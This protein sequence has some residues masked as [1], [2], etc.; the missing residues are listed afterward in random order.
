MRIEVLVSTMHQKDY[1]LLKRMNIKTD[2]IV[3]NQCDTSSHKEFSFNNCKIIWINTKQRGL[4]KSRNM[5][6]SYATGDI[7]VIAD[8]DVKYYDNYASTIYNAYEKEIKADLICFNFKALNTIPLR[9]PNK[10]KESPFYKSY[11][12]VS[13]SFKRKKIEKFGL[14]FNELIG[15]GSKYGAGEESLFLIQSRRYGL[16]IFENSGYIAEV[17][18]SSS[19]WFKGYNEKFYFDKGVYLALAYGKMAYFY[20]FYFILQS[21]KISILPLK[22]VIDNILNGIR[23]FNKI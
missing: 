2:A 18:F 9:L 12:S 6:L 7:C 8:D 3:V 5:A 1:S 20:M 14:H 16:K 17:D 10:D 22:K 11:A 15:A 23:E 21:R 19:T 13:I 4:S